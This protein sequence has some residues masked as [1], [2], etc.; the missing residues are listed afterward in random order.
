[1]LRDPHGIL[2]SPDQRGTGKAVCQNYRGQNR[3][4]AMI[5]E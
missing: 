5:K 1:M 4:G 2:L 3:F